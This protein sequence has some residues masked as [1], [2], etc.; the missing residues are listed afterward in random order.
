MDSAPFI[1]L[2][3]RPCVSI[4]IPCYN[5]ERWIEHAVESALLNCRDGDEVVVVDD[6]SSDETL[7]HLERFSGQIRIETGSHRGGNAARNT[8]LRL[9][10]NEW[11]Q[12]LDADDYLMP[13]KVDSQ[14]RDVGAADT[15]DVIYS[16]V[17]VEKWTSG[18]PGTPE[19]LKIDTRMDLAS[20]WIS[21]DLPQTGAVLWR[22][23]AIEQIGGWNEEM[24]CCQE[25]ELYLRCIMNGL[26]FCFSR[27]AGAVYRIWSEQTVCRRDPVLVGKTRAELIDRMLEWLAATGAKRPFHQRIAGQACFEIARTW[28]KYDLAEA[29][30]FQK[31]RKKM[32]CFVPRGPA[33]PLRYRM[34]LFLFGFYITE[35]IADVARSNETVT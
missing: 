27:S 9:A 8:L 33:A 6:G 13:G 19:E 24:R 14:F 35:R 17:L 32:N 18:L 29:A 16:P 28:A 2:A 5:A 10:R 26:R 30:R 31:E 34:T 20:Q 25:H 1:A 22:K 4:L 12:Y 15:C 21:W 23:S 3:S 11:V 7:G